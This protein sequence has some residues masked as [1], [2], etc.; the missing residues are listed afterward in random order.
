[1]DI[2]WWV[3][4]HAIIDV[5]TY[6]IKCGYVI[7][8]NVGMLA[9][10]MK[11]I[12]PPL[13]IWLPIEERGGGEDY[14]WHSGKKLA[15][16]GH[17]GHGNVYPKGRL[18]LIVQLP[19]HRCPFPMLQFVTLKPEALKF[20]SITMKHNT[21]PDPAFFNSKTPH[22]A[23]HCGVWMTGRDWRPLWFL[24]SPPQDHFSQPPL[25]IPFWMWLFW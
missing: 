4:V 22:Q 9:A 12:I 5:G 11:R 18:L 16:E 15:H 10:R 3:S 6:S 2:D 24:S 25:Q 23:G 7:P 19:T 17:E 14:P 8:L 20:D 1:M 13:P 21:V